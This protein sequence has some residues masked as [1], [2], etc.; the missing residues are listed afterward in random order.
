MYE[1]AVG[2]LHLGERR[3]VRLLVRRD[4]FGRFFSCLVYLPRD[5]FNT[6]NRIRIQEILQEAFG[7]ISVDYDTRVS[8]SVLARLHYVIYTEPGRSVEVDTPEIEARLAQATRGWT[9]DFR[10]A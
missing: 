6:E 10:A 2:I 3:S 9:D 8:E 4:A 7:G 5:R 1:L